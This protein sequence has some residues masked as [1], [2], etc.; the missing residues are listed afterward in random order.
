MQLRQAQ[1]A[2]AA[3]FAEHESVVEH[4]DRRLREGQRHNAGKERDKTVQKAENDEDRGRR[5]GVGDD[6][7]PIVAALVAQSRT[8][9][10]GDDADRRTGGKNRCDLAAVEA[11]R[12]E[13]EREIGDLHAAEGVKRRGRH[14]KAPPDAVVFEPPHRRPIPSPPP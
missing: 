5:S 11:A 12:V 13:P 8:D 14:G 1:L 10:I 7:P 2:P 3:G 4:G 9:E 6:Q